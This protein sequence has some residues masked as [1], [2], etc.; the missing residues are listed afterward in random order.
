MP[1][2][3]LASQNKSPDVLLGNYNISTI[4]HMGRNTEILYKT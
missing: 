1:P 4:F 3:A 2:D